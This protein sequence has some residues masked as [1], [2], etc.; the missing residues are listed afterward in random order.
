MTKFWTI[1]VYLTKLFFL[2][3]FA[4]ASSGANSEIRQNFYNSAVMLEL[5][6]RK[7]LVS[8]DHLISQLSAHGLAGATSSDGEIRHSVYKV[9]SYDWQC[10]NVPLSITDMFVIGHTEKCLL[11]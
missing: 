7:V 11:N 3:S 5:G 8:A 4:I 9:I 6:E 1:S 10:Q 2:L